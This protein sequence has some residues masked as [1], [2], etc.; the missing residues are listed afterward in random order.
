MSCVFCR[1]TCCFLFQVIGPESRNVFLNVLYPSHKSKV[2]VN[3]TKNNAED[4][5]AKLKE[6]QQNL[7][8]DFISLSSHA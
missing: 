3:K 1:K 4:K 7:E 6:Q 2:E 8:I 5:T